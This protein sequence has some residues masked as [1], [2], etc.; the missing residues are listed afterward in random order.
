MGVGAIFISA[1]A[2]SKL[3]TPHHPPES[4]AEILAAS[5]Q[6]IVSFVVLGSIVIHGLSIP[7]FSFGKK[8]HSRTISISR[9]LTGRSTA[10]EPEW[11]V[12]MRRMPLKIG[13]TPSPTLP[14]GEGNG[15][16]TAHVTVEVEMPTEAPQT[17]SNSDVPTGERTEKD[18]AA[19]ADAL[20]V[21]TEV[22]TKGLPPFSPLAQPHNTSAAP[23]SA[24]EISPVTEPLRS[25]NGVLQLKAVH[26]PVAE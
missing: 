21:P 5:L 12:G 24:P 8:V 10:V 16:P 17:T 1:L 6:P 18:A 23:F 15:S 26:F 19:A 4:Q 14:H 2:L 11:V 25:A 3:P 9:T 20:E 7:F 22:A 13:Q